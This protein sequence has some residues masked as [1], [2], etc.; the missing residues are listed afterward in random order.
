MNTE[1]LKN[2]MKCMMIVSYV[3]GFDSTEFDMINEVFQEVWT[4]GAEELDE[5]VETMI[6]EVAGY[7][8]EKMM[9]IQFEESTKS[10]ALSDEVNKSQVINMMMKLI[11]AHSKI[12]GEETK[13]YIQFKQ[14]LM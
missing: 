11:K 13:F 7:N 3:D 10:L 12:T 8:A 1:D 4:S 6:K 14:F 2:L 9:E 5:L